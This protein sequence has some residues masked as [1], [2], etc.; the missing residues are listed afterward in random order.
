[1]K[2]ARM[3]ALRPR[4]TRRTTTRPTV[5]I[6]FEAG[7]RFKGKERSSLVMVK[8]IPELTVWDVIEERL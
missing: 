6:T 5:M 3:T 7:A 8:T 4:P 1:M 2:Y